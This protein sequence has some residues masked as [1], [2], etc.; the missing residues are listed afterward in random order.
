MEKNIKKFFD[1]QPD[2]W[3]IKPHHITKAV[4][5]LG[6]QLDF[7]KTWV[8][9]GLDDLD[10]VE[11]IMGLETDLDIYIPDELAEIIFN[12]KP[13]IIFDIIAENRVDKINKLEIE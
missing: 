11:M 10:L 5:K 8:E 2:L 7:N 3:R 13:S 12:D 4:N 1:Q 9:N 6:I